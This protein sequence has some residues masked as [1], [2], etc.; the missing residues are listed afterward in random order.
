MWG[1]LDPQQR[2]AVYGK[3]VEEKK[4]CKYFATNRGHWVRLWNEIKTYSKYSQPCRALDSEQKWK[5]FRAKKCKRKIN[6]CFIYDGTQNSKICWRIASLSGKT[7]WTK[8][9]IQFSCTLPILNE[10]IG[11]T[12]IVVYDVSISEDIKYMQEILEDVMSPVGHVHCFSSDLRFAIFYTSRYSEM[13][14]D[15]NSTAE[16][17]RKMVFDSDES[18]LGWMLPVF[19][20]GV[21]PFHYTHIVKICRRITDVTCV[22]Q[23]STVLITIQCYPSWHLY[24]G[25][26]TNSNNQPHKNMS[27]NHSCCTNEKKYK[28]CSLRWYDRLLR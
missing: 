7:F 22:V 23:I 4:D 25:L 15:T 27:P 12:G 18:D 24:L 8:Q 28:A 19:Q 3:N 11:T 13:T 26:H 1:S 14:R 10:Q 20:V 16:E 5:V 6:L 2:E 21:S 17:F 9:G